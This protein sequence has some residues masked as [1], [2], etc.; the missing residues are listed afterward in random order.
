M[1]VE[2]MIGQELLYLYTDEQYEKEAHEVLAFIEDAVDEITE[3]EK[4][5][6][7]YAFVSFKKTEKGYVVLVPDFETNPQDSRTEDC[8]LFLKIIHETFEM[9]KKTKTN[10]QLLNFT[11]MNHIIVAHHTFEQTEW[12]AQ[13]FDDSTWYLAP[14]DMTVDTQPLSGYKAYEVLKDHPELY[15]I[16][17]LPIDYIALYA[18]DQLITVLDT[19]NQEVFSA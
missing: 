19:Q 14:V 9:A 2:K 5:E 11:F 8:T 13:R 7:H 6:F 4:I 3:N 18:H 1:I 12:Y 15:S 17:H 10:G 16:L